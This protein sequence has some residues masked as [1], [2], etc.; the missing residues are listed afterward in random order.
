MELKELLYN[1][2]IVATNADRNSDIKAL[3]FDS[4]TATDGTMFFAIKGT[5]NDGHDYISKAI[6]QGCKII[7]LEYGIDKLPSDIQYIQV[8][9][10]SRVLGVIASNFYGNPS[11]K[12]KL[13]GVTGTNGKTTTATLSYELFKNLGYHV[14]LLS[15]VVNKIGDD[16]I[17]STHTT[18]DPITLNRLLAQMV[19]DGCDY[20]FMEVSSHAIVQNR[21]A[22]LD[23]DIAGF[24]NITHDHLDYHHTFKA[25]IEAKKMFFDGLKSS[26][27]AITNADDKNGMVMLQNTQATKYTYGLKSIADFKAK[28]IENQ[29]SGLVLNLDGNEFWTQLIGRFN[30]YNLLLVYTIAVLLDQDKW[31]VLTALSKLQSVEGRFQYIVNDSNVTAIVDYAHTPDALENVLKTITDIRTQ[32]ERVITI[33]GCGGDRDKAKR[34]EMAKIACDYSDQVILTSDNPRSEDPNEIIA[35]M[36]T[37]VEAQNFRKVLSITDRFQAI[38]TACTIAQPNDIILIAGKGHEKYQEIKGVKHDFDDIKV[39][40]DLFEGN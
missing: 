13:I 10:S 21:I 16:V 3:T 28:I 9:D 37:G 24:T 18:P 8:E 40:K 31:E 23:F 1:V 33:V 35:E 15:T 17:P 7:V 39:V 36:Q 32:N 25:Y 34:P 11:Q 14:G 5:N 29:F 6:E 27:K 4:R 12:L 22:G 38:K 30:A 20:C 26:A 19:E 2:S